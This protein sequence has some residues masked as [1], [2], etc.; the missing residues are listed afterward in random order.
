MGVK[1]ITDM[2]YAWR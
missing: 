1:N 2:T